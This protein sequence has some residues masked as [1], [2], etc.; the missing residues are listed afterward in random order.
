MRTHRT[1]RVHNKSTTRRRRPTCQQHSFT[2]K[3]RGIPTGSVFRTELRISFRSTSQIVRNTLGRRIHLDSRLPIRYGK[4]R[5]S[6]FRSR[7]LTVDFDS[8]VANP[9]PVGSYRSCSGTGLIGR[10]MFGTYTKPIIGIRITSRTIDMITEGNGSTHSLDL[11]R[12]G[13]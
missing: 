6:W 2:P 10:F 7:L 4:T 11:V 1:R 3:Q 13:W 8:Y 9:R 5:R 12:T